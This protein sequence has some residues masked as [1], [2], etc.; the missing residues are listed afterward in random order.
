[1]RSTIGA[2]VN[3]FTKSGLARFNRVQAEPYSSSLTIGLEQLD[4]ITNAVLSP[5]VCRKI[6]RLV[7]TIKTDPLHQ[8]ASTRSRALMAQSIARIG[9]GGST[10]RM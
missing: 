1:M 6:K 3:T 8:V 9:A 10:R 7:S 5:A 2:A 4:L